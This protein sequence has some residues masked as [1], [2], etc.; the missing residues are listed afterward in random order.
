MT[1]YKYNG[2]EYDN[3]WQL[4]S[5]NKHLLIS[6]AHPVEVLNAVGIEIITYPDP[7]PVVPPPHVETEEEKLQNAKNKR[8]FEVSVITVTVD[9]MEFDGNETAQRRMSAALDA[10]PKSVET[11]DWVLHDNS[12]RPVTYEQL[13]E[14][15]NQ[16][17]QKML[18]LWI[19]PYTDAEIDYDQL[20]LNSTA[21]TLGMAADYD[22]LNVRDTPVTEDSSSPEEGN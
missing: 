11:I 18:S 21:S 14:A 2:K 9:G 8:T 3:L 17:V 1:K 15:F 5:A 4:K 6:T 19:A 10:W 16:S 20:I 7:E 22:R 13:E 12:V